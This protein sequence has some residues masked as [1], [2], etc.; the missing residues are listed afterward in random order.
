MSRPIIELLQYENPVF[1]NY[2]FWTALLLFK[3]GL[4]SFL[5][6][7]QSLIAKVCD[8]LSDFIKVSV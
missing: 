7:V 6:G 5:P 4:M 1:R 2:A 3:T 8:F